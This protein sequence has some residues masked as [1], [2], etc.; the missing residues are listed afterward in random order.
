MVKNVF[1]IQDNTGNETELD[2][3]ATR[4]FEKIIKPACNTLGFSVIRSDSIPTGIRVEPV[5]SQ[6][7]TAHLVIADFTTSVQSP[8]M[9]LEVGF[10]IATGRPLIILV[11]RAADVCNLPA[12]LSQQVA[13]RID[14]TNP[15]KADVSDLCESLKEQ[16]D[17]TGWKSHFPLIEFSLPLNDPEKAVFISANDQA[18]TLY[19]YSSIEEMLSSSVLAADE[20]LKA[21]MPKQQRIAFEKDQDSMFGRVISPKNDKPAMA[22]VPLWFMKHPFKAHNGQSYWPIMLQHKFSAH[23]ENTMVMR[24]AFVNVSEWDAY[25]VTLTNFSKV[26]NIPKIYRQPTFEF[27]IFLSY[28]SKDASV[29]RTVKNILSRFGL[30]VWFDEDN[31][32]TAGGFWS[33]LQSAIYNSRAVVAVVGTNGF[34]PWQE[35]AELKDLFLQVVRSE[36]PF[37]LLLLD[38]LSSDEPNFWVQYVPPEFG[39]ALLNRLYLQ[40]PTSKELEQIASVDRPHSF[41]ERLIK[42][43]ADTMRGLDDE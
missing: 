21:F 9:L 37:A 15:T 7:F 4:I 34:G 8:D 17:L 35:N 41:A 19:G 3:N 16:Q 1:L 29:V 38:S 36:K 28:N 12:N 14:A 32:T 42:F 39:N 25:P 10:R 13:C 40:L 23:E 2:A 26:R 6:I 20:K 33:E 27:D 11:D 43:F 24:I 22:Q 31:L 18:V 5:I 30:R